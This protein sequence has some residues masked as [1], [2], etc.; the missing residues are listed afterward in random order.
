[1]PYTVTVKP[2][3]PPINTNNGIVGN[4]IAY[5]KDA[6][7][8]ALTATTSTGGSLKWY[9]VASGGNPSSNAP[10]PST[11][12]VGTTNY[13]VS[14]TV[15]GVESDRSLVIVRVNDVPAAITAS[16][17]QPNCSLTSGSILVTSPLGTGYT[18][19]ID[20]TNYTSTTLFTTIPSGNYLVKVKNAEGCISNPTTVT[21]NP[22]VV[23]PL[24]PVTSQV[25]PTCDIRTGT[26]NITS[27]GLSTDSYSIDGGLSYQS[28][29]TFTNVLPGT[30]NVTTLNASGCVSVATIALINAAPAIP[31]QPNISS[32]TSG[33]ICEGTSVTLTSTSNTGNQWYKNGVLIVGAI[34]QTYSPNASGSYT[35]VAT[36][37]SGCSSI[38]SAA[39]LIT[40]N[41]LPTPIISNGAT[42]A[43]NNCAT[44]VITLTASNTT[45]STDNT[46][47]WYLNGNSINVGGNNS[48][49]NA[50][51]A[52]NYSVVI[53][54][55]GCSTTSAISKLIAAP[56]V[57]AANTA[58]CAG[59]S[60][61][62]SGNS[63]GFTNP[64]YQWKVSTDGGLNFVN[65]TGAGTTSLTYTATTAGKY[66]LQVTDGGIVS[67]S[68]PINVTVFTNPTATITASPSASVCV[69]STISLN[70][71]AASGTASYTYQWLLAGG[72]D[73]A[74]ASLST[75]T[76]G[77]S[78]SYEVKVTDANGCSVNT[79]PA[80]ITFNAV[81]TAPVVTITDPTCS[82]NTGTISVTAP[83]GTGYTYSIDGTNYTNTTGL[84]T[85]LTGGVSYNVT[86]KSSSNCISNA[87]VATI[88]SALVIPGQ[89]S[90]ITGPVN[91]IANSLNT[92]SVASIT[93]ATSYTWSIP[94]VW[95][96]VSTSNTITLKV[97]ASAGT[98]SVAGNSA[99]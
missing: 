27:T 28:S 20:G 71:N 29:K 33:T 84:F 68:C 91:V 69:G 15:N 5:C 4:L 54:N 88:A 1:M 92:Y 25:Q 72:N 14:Q 52:G 81:P 94:G 48:T 35:V 40:F 77:V 96:G 89:P 59:G 19:S 38:E 78:G 80:A 62:L 16:A 57:N 58:F 8:F 60:A 66:Q 41:P 75:Y 51:Q 21:I 31:A 85:G 26:I 9:T 90:E 82:V 61:L 49:Y 39:E 67:T 17:T 42:L 36:N 2:I 11:S 10:T 87:T 46:Y 6:S 24:S 99:T 73:I 95:T 76:T 97:N 70:A 3:A 53:T 86:V 79:T 63:T 65:A 34:N 18:Y 7:A 55:N 13:Y 43:F 98:I 37:A 45:T 30:Y 64:T 74:G 83:L 32:N 93:G 44:T 23:P 56:S 50:N 47:Q 22:A 12:L